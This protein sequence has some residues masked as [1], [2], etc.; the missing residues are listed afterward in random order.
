M[1]DLENLERNRTRLSSLLADFMDNSADSF[2]RNDAEIQED[3]VPQSLLKLKKFMLMKEIF[4]VKKNVI[5][6]TA[7]QELKKHIKGCENVHGLACGSIELSQAIASCLEFFH[8]SSQILEDALKN[9]IQEDAL[10]LP[11]ELHR[12][13]VDLFES[14]MWIIRHKRWQPLSYQVEWQTLISKLDLGVTNWEMY[15]KQKGQYLKE[16]QDMR[17]KLTSALERRYSDI[18]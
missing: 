14:C 7:E 11:H 8:N 3:E 18:Y 5:D 13:A 16:V 17:L 9:P 15:A 2:H 1:T 12:K 10:H 6:L 4:E